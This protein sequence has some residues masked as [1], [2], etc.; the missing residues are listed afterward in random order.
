M[1]DIKIKD[2]MFDTDDSYNVY[3]C[4]GPFRIRC[5]SINGF[6]K[7]IK[8]LTKHLEK[9]KKEIEENY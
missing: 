5:S 3:L 7:F 6:S 2:I 8:N 1:K 9:I 4:Y